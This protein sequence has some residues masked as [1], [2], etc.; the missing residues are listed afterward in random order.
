MVPLSSARELKISQSYTHS[1]PRMSSITSP[2]RTDADFAGDVAWDI[3][4][5]SVHSVVGQIVGH[6][7]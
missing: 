1:P 2:Q 6:D 3:A 4:K 5:S 7:L